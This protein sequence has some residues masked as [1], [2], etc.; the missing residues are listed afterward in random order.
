[1]NLLEALRANAGLPRICGNP[2]CNH[3]YAPPAGRVGAADAEGLVFKIGGHEIAGE[4]LNI[5]PDCTLLA[6]LGRK[7]FRRAGDLVE[8]R[9]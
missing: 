1:M 2:A 8:I 5:C 9:K 6:L 4:D 3:W 7:P